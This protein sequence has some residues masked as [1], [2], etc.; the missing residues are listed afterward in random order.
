MSDQELIGWLALK[1]IPRLGDAGLKKLMEVFESA[2][3]VCSASTQELVE[4][5]ELPEPLASATKDRSLFR[6][7]EAELKAIHRAGITVLSL[8]DPDYPRSLSAISNP[9]PILYMKG[10]MIPTDHQAI[11][12]VGSRKASSYGIR[13][14]THLA[15]DLS[16][17]GFTI[18]SGLA[19]GVDSAAHSGALNGGGRTFAVL[20]CGLDI[21]YP[22][23]NA[24]LREEI[25]E[26]GAIFSEFPL[27][28][29]PLSGNFPHRNRIISGLALGTLVVEAAERSGSLITAHCALEQ[30]REVFAIPGNLGAA[31]SQ[32]TNRLIKAGAKLVEGIEDILEE[33][34]PQLGYRPQSLPRH[35]RA[36]SDIVLEPIE[37]TL[38]EM[39]SEEPKHIDELIM[40]S[41][42]PSAQVSGI[43]LQLELKGNVKQL[44]GQLYIRS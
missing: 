36:A 41:S 24:T 31:N 7:A 25:I 1:K 42:L 16:A 26:H 39:L 3:A 30:G 22:R 27:G 13:T 23:E 44:S 33:L 38:Y 32:G 8:K 35:R 2:E 9:P 19:R 6:K 17:F 10:Q 37:E 12:I 4:R 40:Q 15:H 21:P 28:T 34:N 11:A 5:A 43:L 29:P 14:A 20:G 18:V